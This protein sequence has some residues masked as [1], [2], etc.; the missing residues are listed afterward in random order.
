MFVYSSF[1][2][3]YFVGG[4]ER[5]CMSSWL[6]NFERY[7]VVLDV[8]IRDCWADFIPSVCLFV[9]GTLYI[10]SFEYVTFCELLLFSWS[11]SFNV[12]IFHSISDELWLF[13]RQVGEAG[14]FV[15]GVQWILWLSIRNKLCHLSLRTCDICV[16]QVELWLIEGHV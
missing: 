14:Q 3:A 1:L 11:T 5:V 6:S 16:W 2:V 13:G 7:I 12:V 4:V 15:D 9:L 8:I 10:E